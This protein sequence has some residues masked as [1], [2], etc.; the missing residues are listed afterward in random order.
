MTLGLRKG[1]TCESLDKNQATSNMS[2]QL[3]DHI[4]HF[5][6]PQG[7]MWVFMGYNTH[8]ITPEGLNKA[9]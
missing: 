5:H 1:S 2:N 4:F 9:A 6:L 8:F 7:F 3:G